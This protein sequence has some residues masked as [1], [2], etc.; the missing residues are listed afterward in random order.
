M[1]VN[2][3]VYLYYLYRTYVLT[4]YYKFMYVISKKYK[5]YDIVVV[6]QDKKKCDVLTLNEH[7]YTFLNSKIFTSFII[8]THYVYSE[9]QYS[10]YYEIILEKL[11][12]YSE[13]I[14]K[15]QY[16]SIQLSKVKFIGV[17]I[18]DH[19]QT[20]QL[21][22]EKFLVVS[23]C[24]FFKEFNLWLLNHYFKSKYDAP[25]ITILDENINLI[26]LKDESITIFENDYVKTI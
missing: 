24:L 23:N 15:Y 12:T 16:S 2:F 4:F 18:K 17:E 20:F 8:I 5:T 13:F 3:I 21:P 1:F 10:T 11:P 26:T 7:S 9:N 22:I 25:I 6:S 19:D 14:D